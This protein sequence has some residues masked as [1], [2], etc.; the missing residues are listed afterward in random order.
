VSSAE[1][2][3]TSEFADHNNQPVRD[4][5]LD[6]SETQQT[7]HVVLDPG[8]VERAERSLRPREVGRESG[9]LVILGGE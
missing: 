8:I 3:E 7:S 5:Y 4:R 1:R 2:R 9:E 6:G